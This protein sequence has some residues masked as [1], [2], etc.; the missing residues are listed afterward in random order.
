MQPVFENI[1]YS[2]EDYTF[3]NNPVTVT[4][5]D[6]Y[7]GLVGGIM[8]TA[9][10]S[11][12]MVPKDSAVDTDIQTKADTNTNPSA[13]V[14]NKSDGKLSNIFDSV[15]RKTLEQL[16][17][18]HAMAADEAVTDAY[19][20]RLKSEGVNS[21]MTESYK[22]QS[23]GSRTNKASAVEHILKL[24]GEYGEAIKAKVEKIV[25]KG[26]TQ[27]T[28]SNIANSDQVSIEPGE[29]LQTTQPNTL[30]TMTDTQ[31]DSLYKTTVNEYADM[32]RAEDFS[33]A[34]IEN[35]LDI[36]MKTTGVENQKSAIVKLQG[37]MGNGNALNP[38]PNDATIALS[39]SPRIVSSNEAV[40]EALPQAYQ[41]IFADGK[42][43]HILLGEVVK[44]QAKGFHYEG[45]PEPIGRIIPGT[46]F[47]T[48]S[49]GIYKAQVEINGIKKKSNEGYSTF[50]PKQ[51]SAQE[52]VEAIN[53]AYDS[54]GYIRGNTYKGITNSGI[55]IE[56][57]INK[58]SKIISAYPKYGRE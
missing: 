57:Y 16:S 22:K 54:R 49:F 44:G 2:G 17:E 32:L 58:D 4:L 19:A 13:K 9:F 51:W 1:A 14:K 33:E 40:L 35:Y 52:V 23:A 7:D 46:E 26:K 11:V 30:D 47:G 8:G 25:S 53:E 42:L 3:K 28:D 5:D 56:M 15:T 21:D 29:K 6:V 24:K 45:M 38:K 31:V 18:A 39:E 55:E 43:I 36:A 41:D 10:E 34:Q 37:E 27:N 12:G 48:D 50:F 20:E